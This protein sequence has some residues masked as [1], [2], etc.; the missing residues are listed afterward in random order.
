MDWGQGEA[1]AVSWAEA[2]GFG[3]EGW[4]DSRREQTLTPACSCVC[5]CGQVTEL[6][7]RVSCRSTGPACRVLPQGG[8]QEQ[9][10]IGH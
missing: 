2:H 5:G 7:E 6:P 4:V 1:D 9:E 3:L 10:L 8:A